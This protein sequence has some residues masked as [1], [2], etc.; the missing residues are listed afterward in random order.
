MSAHDRDI[1]ARLLIALPAE[2]RQD[3]EPALFRLLVGEMRAELQALLIEDVRLTAHAGS[4]LAREIVLSGQERP[5]EPA[6]LERQWRARAAVT[7]RR[8]EAAAATLGWRHDFRIV[9]G[10]PLA[11]LEAAAGGVDVMIV[12]AADP[13]TGSRA[14]SAA[15]L[16]RLAA[17]RLRALHVARAGWTRGREIIA[18][19]TEEADA[20]LKPA[21]VLGTALRLANETG[22]T[23]GIVLAGRA[24]ALAGLVA[25]ELPE[26]FA[27][28]RTIVAVP[29][30]RGV[31]AALRGRNARLLVLPAATADDEELVAALLA[32]LSSSLLWLR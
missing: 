22:S 19:L 8:F 2:G 1:V 12:T 6:T 23:L 4:R 30:T 11:E 27:R 21:S 24:A 9:R 5:L 32:Q 25:A 26:A 29:G 20:E 15:D 31:A 18:V 28:E 16:H 3:F 10:E 17:G 14:W 13:A 7:R